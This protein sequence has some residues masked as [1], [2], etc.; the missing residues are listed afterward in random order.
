MPESMVA[1][2]H[3]TYN[4]PSNWSNRHCKRHQ[5]SLQI[6]S[7]CDIHIRPPPPVSSKVS[8]VVSRK[9][10]SCIW[11]RC[12]EV[13]RHVRGGWSTLWTLYTEEVSQFPPL[14]SY[15]ALKG[16]DHVPTAVQGQAACLQGCTLHVLFV[17]FATAFVKALQPK[18]KGTTAFGTV[19]SMK[20]YP[21]LLIASVVVPTCVNRV[22]SHDC[23]VY[24]HTG[25]HTNV[26]TTRTKHTGCEVLRK[27]IGN[28]KGLTGS[29]DVLNQVSSWRKQDG[30]FH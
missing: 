4:H 9:V 15:W 20:G 30:S 18:G 28:S 27:G 3:C 16:K 14:Q 21:W 2:H 5:K 6:W 13:G 25:I 24:L 10:P 22:H 7:I 26:C 8:I 23:S 12:G 19:G 1:L 17:M 11:R 29:K